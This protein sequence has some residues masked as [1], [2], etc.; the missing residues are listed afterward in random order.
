MGAMALY[1]YSSGSLEPVDKTSLA[2]EKIRERQDL[3]RALRQRIDVLGD[4]LLVVAEEYA[5]FKDSR[6]RVDL[7]ALDRAGTLVVIEL[8]RTDTAGT[9]S[10]RRCGTPRWSRR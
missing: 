5:V 8:K 9:W 4:D 3:Q 6:R 10:S 2:A 7:L 1:R